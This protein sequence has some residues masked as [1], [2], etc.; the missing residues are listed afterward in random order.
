M[1]RRMDAEP[2]RV[3]FEYDPAHDAGMT[4]ASRT[5]RSGLAFAAFRRG[6]VQRRLDEGLGRFAKIDTH[7]TLLAGDAVLRL[8]GIDV[9][10]FRVAGGLLIL[11][12]AIS[13]VRGGQS[14][15]HHGSD[16]E[17]EHF[18]GRD[19][20]GVYPLGV[21]MLIGPGSISTLVVFRAQAGAAK[22][23]IAL[24]AALAVVV[25]LV[26]AAFLGGSWLARRLG[27]ASVTIMGRIM[28]MILAAIA[29]EMIATGLKA[30]MPGLAG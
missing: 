18:E 3:R 15:I 21:P 23:A 8:F 27:R 24:W 5:S 1:R 7:G 22:E 4:P 11:L 2:A 17:K 28:G 29:V 13:M 14:G 19:S 16:E 12:I 6:L 25:A 20:P 9:D 10:D 26:I 30:L